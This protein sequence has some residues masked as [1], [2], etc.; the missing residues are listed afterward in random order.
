MPTI[1]T[2]VRV[3]SAVI[4]LLPVFSKPVTACGKNRN[5]TAIRVTA[6]S[7]TLLNAIM[8]NRR[9]P[10]L[11]TTGAQQSDAALAECLGRYVK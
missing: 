6:H 8:L 9:L 1:L 3:M 5:T 10:S 2:S 4:W 7:M 11:A